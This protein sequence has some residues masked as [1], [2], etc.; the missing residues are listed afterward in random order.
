MHA[1]EDVFSPILLGV[2]F[3]STTSVCLCG[4][5]MAMVRTNLSNFTLLLPLFYFFLS[6]LSSPA[7]IYLFLAI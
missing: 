7:S 2:F 6:L 5:S 1:I 3:I 4:F